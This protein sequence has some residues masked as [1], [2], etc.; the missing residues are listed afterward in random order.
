MDAQ[1]KQLIDLQTEQNQLLKKHLWRFRFSLMTLLFLTTATCC[2]LGFVIYMQRN[3]LRPAPAGPWTS[4]APANSAAPI[5]AAPTPV[6][7]TSN[8][9]PAIRYLAIPSNADPTKFIDPAPGQ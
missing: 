1:L 4:Y 9:A 2:C 3:A 5:Y 7:A 6:P 8:V